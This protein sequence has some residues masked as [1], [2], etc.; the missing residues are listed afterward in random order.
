MAWQQLSGVVESCLHQ[1][2][3]FKVAHLQGHLKLY[4]Q[5][6]SA[7]VPPGS[8]VSIATLNMVCWPQ[9]TDNI[10]TPLKLTAQWSWPSISLI[11]RAAKGGC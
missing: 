2:D 6:Y 9:T 3:L 1:E 7:V 4:R 11:Y 5:V 10:V 8:A